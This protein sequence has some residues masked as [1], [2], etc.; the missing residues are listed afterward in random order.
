MQYFIDVSKDLDDTKI[1]D[2]PTIGNSMNYC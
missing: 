2:A 1:H